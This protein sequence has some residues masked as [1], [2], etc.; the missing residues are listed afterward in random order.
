[1]VSVRSL[2]FY[3]VLAFINPFTMFELVMLKPIIITTTRKCYIMIN[4]GTICLFAS[5]VRHATFIWIQYCRCVCRVRPSV[6]L[7]G[8]DYLPVTR[9]ICNGPWKNRILFGLPFWMVF[10][11]N[12]LFVMEDFENWNE[13]IFFWNS[14]LWKQTFLSF[15][16]RIRKCTVFTDCLFFLK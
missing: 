6:I 7:L 14:H 15:I 10:L 9:T 12:I 11:I 16:S 3:S 8:R 5:F 1:M 2:K 13:H 4:K